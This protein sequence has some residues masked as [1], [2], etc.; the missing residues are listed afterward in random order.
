MSFA[1]TA[2]TKTRPFLYHTTLSD[3]FEAIRRD[4]LLVSARDSLLSAGRGHLVRQ[5]REYIL[6]LPGVALMDQ[7][8]LREANLR[9][10]GG[11][12]F[13]D[14]LEALNSRVFFWPGDTNGPVKPGL[15][16]FA[17]YHDGRTGLV[18]LR[19]RATAVFSAN[20]APEFCRY[21]SGAPRWSTR[22]A[23]P[24]GPDLFLPS[25]RFPGPPSSVKEVA[26]VG[27][28]RVPDDSEWSAQPTGPWRPL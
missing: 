25:N 21:N 24:R 18:V 14:L 6:P 28:V 13:E 16:H 10:A 15:K 19:T 5:R 27:S 7:G 9:L 17:R 8:P 20:A 23:P 11:W 22:T 2:F 4:R 12:T 3:N 26:F 1:L